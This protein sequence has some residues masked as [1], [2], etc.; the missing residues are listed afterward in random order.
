MSLRVEDS[1]AVKAGPAS[2]T[3]KNLRPRRNYARW[4]A[5]TLSL[6]Y[7]VFG[8]HII[9]WKMTG[10]TLAPLELNEVM[11]TLELGIITAGF[12]FMCALVLG[13]LIFGRFFCSW[14][15]H[16]MVLQDLCAWVLRK[17][18]IRPVQIRSRL[19]LWVPALT[20]LYMF[21][22]PQ[23]VR[24]WH[25]RALPTFHFATDRQG[26]ASFVTENFW[27]NLP[28]APII[29]LTFIVCGFVIVYL[30]GSRSFCTYVC[31]Y[32]A[33]FALADRFSPGRIKLTGE[34][35]QCGT[36]TAACT[37][38]VRVH[39]E[40]RLHG[41]VVNPACLKDLDCVSACPQQAIQYGMGRPAAWRSDTTVGRFGIPY[42]F[43][44]YEELLMAVVFLVTALSLRGLYSRIPFLL[45]LASGAIVAYLCV[46]AIRLF[47]KSSVRIATLQLKTAG[48]W[49]HWGVA[50]AAGFALLVV[51]LG[52]CALVRYHE[53]LGL[54]MVRGIT[55]EAVESDASNLAPRTVDHLLAADRW[56][57]IHN[58]RVE[59]GLVTAGF[60]SGRWDVVDQFS[61][62]VLDRYPYDATTRVQ[63]ARSLLERDRTD[64]AEREL[65]T[66]ITQWQV[67]PERAPPAVATAYHILG[68]LLARRGDFT[69][70]AAQ[71][72][73]ALSLEPE[74][75][76]IHAD[77]GGVLA[78]LGRFDG[79]I[80]QFR[81]ALRLD[82]S[83]GDAAYNLGTILSHIGRSAEA[84]DAFARAESQMG[85]DPDMQ[86]NYGLVL[87]QAGR[88]SEARTHLEKALAL[89]PDHAGAHFNLGRVLLELGEIN[90]AA[91]QLE[92]AA[93]LDP[94]YA[95]LLRPDGGR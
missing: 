86:N 25:D 23:V 36:C 56:G 19:L 69:G 49:T 7:V 31:P 38:G 11:Y 14:A 42:S 75:A 39:E 59:R 1:Q 4:R 70:A 72:A 27:R 48:N 94:R 37:S 77:L 92:R 88:P 12:L 51:F 89:D 85:D 67:D 40:I 53:Y 91:V 44:L 26:W 66:A 20:A 22:W 80:D 34:C 73:S 79:A 82:N 60:A 58:E 24:T 61:H 71:Y 9:H 29:I 57:L 78:E 2:V 63:L 28:S 13:T 33:I 93:D 54:R 17:L 87:L 16:I 95:A 41:R 52:H 83:L 30:L 18:H 65:R 46:M 35:Q 68:G 21:V 3:A 74:A 76:R 62:R 15:C 55:T 32:G 43:T 90:A 84:I 8:A 81:E 6:V 10:K 64:D 45:S 47:R 5:L 50:Y